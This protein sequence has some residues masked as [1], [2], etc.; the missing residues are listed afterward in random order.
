MVA[1]TQDHSFLLFRFEFSYLW[2]IFIIQ[3][4]LK[5][6]LLVCSEYVR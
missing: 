5:S 6:K 4:L 3:F 1:H 2:S